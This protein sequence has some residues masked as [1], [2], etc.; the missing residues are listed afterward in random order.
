MIKKYPFYSIYTQEAFRPCTIQVRVL[1]VHSAQNHEMKISKD[2]SKFSHVCSLFDQQDSKVLHS[3]TRPLP[4]SKQTS[5]VEM[6][7]KW[8]S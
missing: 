1:S 5:L 8:F 4:V 7:V 6:A 3:N 2:L